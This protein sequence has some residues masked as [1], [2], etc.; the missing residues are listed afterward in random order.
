MFLYGT[1]PLSLLH[2]FFF[3]SISCHF[4]FKL[5]IFVINPNFKSITFFSTSIYKLYVTK[6]VVYL[7]IFNFKYFEAKILKTI[8]V[9]QCVHN[10]ACILIYV[11]PKDLGIPA[12]QIPS[13]RPTLRSKKC[14]RTNE[15]NP[16][17]QIVLSSTTISSAGQIHGREKRHVIRGGPLED[18]ERDSRP[19]GLAI[20]GWWGDNPRRG[21]HLHIKHPQ[22]TL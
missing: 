7:A 3:F 9:V 12:H 14:P 22:L 5:Q 20:G 16:D 17:L 13:L 6:F 4:S 19:Y 15:E 8:N 1:K 18:R 11:G 2:L 10:F 21:H